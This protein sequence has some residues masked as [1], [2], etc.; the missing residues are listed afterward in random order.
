MRYSG[1]P[2]RTS[3]SLDLHQQF[4]LPAVVAVER[5]DHAVQF[6]ALASCQCLVSGATGICQCFGATGILPVPRQTS[7]PHETDTPAKAAALAATPC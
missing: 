5:L 7:G 2:R 4:A 3:S 1:T 6:G